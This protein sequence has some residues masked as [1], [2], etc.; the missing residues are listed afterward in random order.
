MK[1]GSNIPQPPNILLIILSIFLF[2]AFVVG[3]I[4]GTICLGL[5]NGFVYIFNMEESE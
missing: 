3:V 5:Y 2:P 4:I 1:L